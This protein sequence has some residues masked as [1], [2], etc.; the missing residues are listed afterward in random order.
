MKQSYAPQSRYVGA[1][2]SIYLYRLG[3]VYILVRGMFAPTRDVHAASHV[4]FAVIGR[5]Y[6]H[7]LGGVPVRRCE[8]QQTGGRY[9]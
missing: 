3:H 9:Q 6:L 7:R 8:R 4:R 5:I 1:R 2:S